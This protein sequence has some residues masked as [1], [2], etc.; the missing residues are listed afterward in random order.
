MLTL[1][2]VDDWRRVKALDVYSDADARAIYDE[3][4]RRHSRSL[5]GTRVLGIF[6]AFIVAI[7]GMIFAGVLTIV[8]LSFVIDSRDELGW[9]VVVMSL[10][11]G[12]IAG[13]FMFSSFVHDSLNTLILNELT[14]K[15]GD[16]LRCKSC[17]YS[18]E[19][20]PERDERLRCPE[21]A[22]EVSTVPSCILDDLGIERVGG[23]PRARIRRR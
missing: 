1:K 11:A 8:V 18:L 23:V 20:L 12:P 5:A 17:G 16:L 15:L 4:V 19:G 9:M 7:L 3:T 6:A 14:P 10:L 2:K 22:R 13:L 21:C